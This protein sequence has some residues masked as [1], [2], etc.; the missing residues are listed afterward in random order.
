[1]VSVSA[2]VKGV[3][4][5]PVLKNGKLDG[6]AI[7]AYQANVAQR[8]LT[9]AQFRGEFPLDT[10]QYVTKVDGYPKRN[11][12]NAERSVDLDGDIRYVRF[13]ATDQES[14]VDALL[15]MI[16]LLTRASPFAS[17]ISS[18]KRSGAAFRKRHYR[19][20]F[21]LLRNNRVVVKPGPNFQS[22]ARGYIRKY[23][24]SLKDRDTLAVT[25]VQP[26]ARRI[27]EGRQ[28]ESYW[29]KQ[30]KR[31]V[32][33]RARLEAMRS[34]KTRGLYISQVEYGPLPGG[35]KES[36]GNVTYAEGRNI[37]RG[38]GRRFAYSGRIM[39]K[40]RVYPILFF[41]PPRTGG[42][43][44]MNQSDGRWTTRQNVYQVMGRDADSRQT[45]RSQIRRAGGAIQK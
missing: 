28:G 11:K 20:S 34:A 30:A 45:I 15:E 6:E 24:D 22:R 27:E 43:Y 18:D 35:I 12:S 17:K 21:A 16:R 33:K 5:G 25:N 29:S 31:G 19:S 26:Y 32:F 39:R 2:S 14:I 23:G 42:G 3:N 4:I 38:K 40:H 41:G 1:M 13:A 7:R 10:K 8:L 36:Q 37:G 44:G 9:S